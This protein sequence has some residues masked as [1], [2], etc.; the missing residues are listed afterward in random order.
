MLSHQQSSSTTPTISCFPNKKSIFLI[1]KARILISHQP[2]FL[3]QKHNVGEQ[4]I[5]KLAAQ[6]AN[7]ERK[8]LHARKE[9][10]LLFA[11]HYYQPAV[12][13][14]TIIERTK[15]NKLNENTALSCMWHHQVMSPTKK[16]KREA[17]SRISKAIASRLRLH[18]LTFIPYRLEEDSGKIPLA[19][20]W[21]DNLKPVQTESNSQM[22]E[23]MSE[24]LCL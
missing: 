13:Y 21:K 19:E 14:H 16:K 1:K 2:K 12:N 20:A 24:Y 7:K 17:I 9:F 5:E 3:Y 6:A 10:K 18:L 22:N 11:L 8:E 4:T 15:F 23:E